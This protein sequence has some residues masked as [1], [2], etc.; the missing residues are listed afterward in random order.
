MAATS[1]SAA[2]AASTPTRG[3]IAS[4]SGSALPL[5]LGIVVILAALSVSLTEMTIGRSAGQRGRH[6]EVR[7]AAAVESAAGETL[8]WMHGHQALLAALPEHPELVAD[9]TSTPPRGRPWADQWEKLVDRSMSAP[10][11][12]RV[13]AKIPD[14][15]IITNGAQPTMIPAILSQSS[16]ATTAVDG[17]GPIVS[18]CA[19]DTRNGCAITSYIVCL[20]RT[21]A[22]HA[23]PDG[24]ERFAVFTVATLGDLAV[25]PRSFQRRM[26]QT[27][28]ATGCSRPFTQALYASDSL[29]LSGPARTD[30]WLGGSTAYAPLP[31]SASP[32]PASHG[33][34]VCAGTM[35]LRDRASIHGAVRQDERLA[36]PSIAGV[37]TDA[38]TVANL[39][40]SGDV[41]LAGDAQ[42]GQVSYRAR[43]VTGGLCFSGGGT[44]RL[45]CEGAFAPRSMRFSPGSTVEV[46]II[47]GEHDAKDVV[48]GG[49]TRVPT[50]SGDV[51]R[52]GAGGSDGNGDDV[53]APRRLVFISDA[54]IEIRIAGDGALAAV[55]YA[56]RA[57]LTLA[58]SFQLFGA[59]IA[60]S[61]DGAADATFQIHY[62]ES[63]WGMTLPSAPTLSASG[64][65]LVSLSLGNH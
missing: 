65:S 3:T 64:W 50:G 26:V 21:E 52:R 5:A 1:V 63:L 46:V 28:V 7:L 36:L 56:P 18:G 49:P 33:D 29:V 40:F 53:A 14:A 19:A 57:H 60:R 16:D 45:F 11:A 34:V 27:I 38:V 58:G 2:S 51:E 20:H 22:G 59:L 12:A 13:G 4:E 47:Q 6:D 30:S 44:V 25:D 15:D 41:T 17:R 23:W 31:A 43:T 35:S 42:G 9:A 55:V 37:V 24:H 39:D 32:A 62:D 10:V 48:I 8:A 61:I 54:D